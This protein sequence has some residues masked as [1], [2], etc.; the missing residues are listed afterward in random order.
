MD[1]YFSKFPVT[2]YDN[3]LCKNLTRRVKVD[4]YVIETQQNTYYP[5]TIESY[6][7]P[8]HLAE[9][10]YTDPYLDWILYLGT[11][12]IDPYYGW[13]LTDK[14]FDN[15]IVE[16]YGSL[17][18]AIKKIKY[19]RMNW[20]NV[21]LEIPV[22]VYENNIPLEFRKYYTPNYGA[23]QKILSYKRRE[24]DWTTNTNQIIKFDVTYN[25][26]NTF[27][28]GELIDIKTGVEVT[29]NSGIE[30]VCS[31]TSSV[32]IKHA[33]GN[34]EISNFIVGE[35]SNANATIT[36]RTYVANNIGVAERVFW[37]PVTMYDYEAEKNEMNRNIN[38]VMATRVK[39]VSE[40]VRLIL[41]Q[42]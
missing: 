15:F 28:D 36:S 27:I 17:E 26:S 25:N 22:S 14:E 3:Q 19:F 23:N 1:N 32:T 18:Y 13:V 9:N 34:T 33:S 2:F 8:D 11:G 4:N 24:E 37:S 16:K 7:R 5:Y 40:K 38:V 12:I 35:T 20:A 6:Q 39:E 10:Y 41:K 29:S 42:E 30:V 21:D 31:N